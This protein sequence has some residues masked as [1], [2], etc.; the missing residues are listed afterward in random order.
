MLEHYE[1]SDLE[2]HA[3]A[4][5]AGIAFVCQWPIFCYF[6]WVMKGELRSEILE[7]LD[8]IADLPVEELKV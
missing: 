1:A 4:L 7:L 3:A 8:L 6:R 5:Y 2:K